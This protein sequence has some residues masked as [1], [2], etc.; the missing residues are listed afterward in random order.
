MTQITIYSKMADSPDYRIATGTTS[1]IWEGEVE[2]RDLEDVFRYFNRVEEADAD[3]LDEIDYR[4]PSLSSG[5]VVTVG[6][7]HN[8]VASMGFKEISPEELEA[9]K[10]ADSLTVMRMTRGQ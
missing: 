1:P 2:V 9:L 7:I 3:R 6:G 10:Q 5:D 8:L 4:L